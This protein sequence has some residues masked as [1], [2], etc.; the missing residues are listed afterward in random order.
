MNRIY[1][2]GLLAIL[3]FSSCKKDQSI[4]GLWLV[5]SVKI[6]DEEMT[7]NARWTRFH[8]DFTQESG[9]GWFQ[10]SIGTWQLDSESDRLKIINTNGINDNNEAF[11]ISINGE[12][13]TWTRTE[14]GQALTV[15]LIRI[16]KLPQTHG[17]QILG[18]WKLEES[19]GEGPYFK[20][21]SESDDYL[22]FRWDKRFV[23]GTNEG[24]I[25]GVYN[26]HGHK[27]ELELIPYGNQYERYFWK[28]EFNDNYLILSI[29]NSDNV[30]TRRFVRIH[31]F[32]VVDL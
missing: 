10:H 5:E 28:I 18:L 27:S 7:P 12:E 6:G 11:Q 9:N 21:S 13:M 32:I 20:A 31:D 17:D 24:K 25:N 4:V 30:V 8:A 26:T 15:N 19:K 2:F 1:I 23:I 16:E 14:E 3:V 29:L 22:F